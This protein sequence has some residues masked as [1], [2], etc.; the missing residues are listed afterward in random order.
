MFN[1][2]EMTRDT[3]SERKEMPRP[4]FSSP[5]SKHMSSTCTVTGGHLLG[6]FLLSL[7]VSEFS[8]L[9]HRPAILSK[10]LQ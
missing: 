1:N 4:V 7:D 8:S 3:S 5:L 9:L 10:V 6:K 2:T